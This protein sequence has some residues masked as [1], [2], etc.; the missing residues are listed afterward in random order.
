M[1]TGETLTFSVSEPGP[2]F[3]RTVSIRETISRTRINVYRQ[4]HMTTVTHS[5]ARYDAETPFQYAQDPPVPFAAGQ[6][7]NGWTPIPEQ[8]PEFSL[9]FVIDRPNS[10]LLYGLKRRGMGNGLSVSF[11]CSHAF[12]V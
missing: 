12:H 1:W 6:P 2:N 7:P 11:Q 9:T 5:S 4:P 8:V 3:R 10:K